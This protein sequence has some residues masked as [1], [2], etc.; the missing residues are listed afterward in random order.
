M[1]E[2]D[3]KNIIEIERWRIVLFLSYSFL[4]RKILLSYN[5]LCNY[6]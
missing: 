3:I 1:D 2:L 5:M 6:I 4:L